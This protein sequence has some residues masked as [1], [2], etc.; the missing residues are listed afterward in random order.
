VRRENW[1][2]QQSPGE[3]VIQL[4]VASEED[5]LQSYIAGQRF[6]APP[7]YYRREGQGTYVL[8]LGPYGS[9]R[10]ARRAINDL[11]RGLRR[12]QPW[13]RSMASVQ[14]ELP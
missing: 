5:R 1:F 11:P 13:V 3:Y 10:E 9:Q 14:Q 6:P 2:R 4:L 8:V 7:A 12:N